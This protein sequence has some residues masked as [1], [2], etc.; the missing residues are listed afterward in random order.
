[1]PLE[2]GR[3]LSWFRVQWSTSGKSVRFLLITIAI[4]VIAVVLAQAQSL[5]VGLEVGMA[6]VG[7]VGERFMIAVPII[8]DGAV[9]ASNVQVT[10]ATWGTVP[11]LSPAAF[12][13]A[14]GSIAPDANAIFQA[15]FNVTGVQPKT[16]NVLTLTGTYQVNE[17]TFNFTLTSSVILPQLGPT[18]IATAIGIAV[19]ESLEGSPYPPSSIPPAPDDAEPGPPIPTGP[20]IARIQSEPTMVQSA[21]N[22]S[23]AGTAAIKAIVKPMSLPVKITPSQALVNPLCDNC[24][25]GQ[26]DPN[27]PSGASGGG[28]LFMSFNWGAVY[29]VEG[30]NTFTTVDP[31]IIFP[32]HPQSIY[33]FCCDQ[34]VEYVPP[35]IDRFVW[36]QQLT[37]SGP[38]T[39]GAY[40]LAA[41]SPA[42]II[43]F[44][45]QKDAWRTWLITPEQMHFNHVTEFDRPGLSVGDNYLYI[46]WDQNCP[47]T[48]PPGK[49]CIAGR[50][51]IRVPLAGI[52]A[53]GGLNYGYLLDPSLDATAWGDYPTEDT[54]DTVYWLGANGTSSMQVFYWPE[55]ST[56]IFES[57]PITVSAWNV[58]YAGGNAGHVASNAPYPIVG[59]TEMATSADWL[60]KGSAQWMTATRAGHVIWFAWNAAPSGNIPQPY[61]EMLGI[62][63]ATFTKLSQGQIWNPSYAFGLAALATNAC[64]QEIGVS[65]A[66]GG[67]PFYPNHAVGFWGDNL[68]FTT[69]AG[70]ATGSSYGDFLSIRQ[71]S[72]SDLHGAY[73]DA[74]GYAL[75]NN[76]TAGAAMILPDSAVN[77]QTQHVVFGRP[78]VCG[79]SQ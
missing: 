57:A 13:D 23:A 6:G 5:L 68:L 45:G 14:L 47:M 40:R 1:M 71:N 79:Q 52:Q 32:H 75:Q 62:D 31:H 38:G 11:V 49:P 76:A 65:L 56:F 7:L 21:A 24:A 78:G 59:G 39:P 18:S 16:Q 50:E 72:A 25:E 36:V 61:I 2:I 66:Y 15:D 4:I 26:G 27:E 12:P 55:S 41:A 3:S 20:F 28:V 35:P 9:T 30:T 37:Q 33:E 44:N 46:G 67:G 54:G 77:V 63:T 51:V 70:S 17:V 64:T 10:G 8:N 53:G 43:K 42:D 48:V 29:Q 60:Y 19:P 34:V 74:F 73:F 69:T 22:A 58:N